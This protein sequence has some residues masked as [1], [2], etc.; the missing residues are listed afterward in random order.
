MTTHDTF[1]SV[2]DED[3]IERVCFRSERL[4]RVEVLEGGMGDQKCWLLVLLWIHTSMF[5]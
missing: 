5:K 1:R 3:T 4:L 2:M